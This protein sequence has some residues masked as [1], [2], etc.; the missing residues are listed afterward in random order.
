MKYWL[1]SIFTSFLFN[2]N[3]QLTDT[4]CIKSRWIS[5]KSN[6]NN[7]PLFSPLED[8]S[9]VL[10]FIKDLMESGK[11]WQ[12]QC[13]NPYFNE[14]SKNWMKDE[15]TTK[16]EVAEYDTVFADKSSKQFYIVCPEST[17]PL[18]NMYGEDSVYKD[19]GGN[20]YY[21]YPIRT[22]YYIDTEKFSE[23]IIQEDRIFNEEKNVFEFQ[24]VQIGFI[25]DNKGGL[26]FNDLYWLEFPELCN[27]LESKGFYKW[28]KFLKEKKYLGFQY[29]QKSCYSDDY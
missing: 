24:T 29:A 3:A 15:W 8:G 2:L 23:I 6:E 25:F 18:S 13:N 27:Q 16:E 19:D 7:K 1:F 14:L 21:V 10:F 17:T 12:L 11:I 20:E 26:R 9:H 28:S 5:I 4:T 22:S